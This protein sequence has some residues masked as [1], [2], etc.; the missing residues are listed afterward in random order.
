MNKILKNILHINIFNDILARR[1]EAAIMQNKIKEQIH[2]QAV[3]IAGRFR[4]AEAELVDILQQVERHYIYLQKGYQSLHAYVVKELALSENVA[5]N[6]ITVSRKAR[7]VPELKAALANGTIT[8]SNAR[9]I[10]PVLSAAKPDSLQWIN[11]AST[12][13]QRALEKEIVKVRPELATPERAVY[14]SSNAEQTRMRLE[15]GMSEE[16]LVK[17]RRVQDLLSQSRKKPVTLEE[18][19]VTLTDDYIKRNDPLE[20]AK[21]Q[22][23][24]KS[25][26]KTL[27][28]PV[29]LQVPTQREPI[30]ATLFHQIA[31]RDE[32]RCTHVNARGTRC[33][34]RRWIEIHHKIPVSLGGKNT[35]E[36]L[37][38]LC[39]THHRALHS[40]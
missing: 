34:Q 39:S 18:V 31:L 22:L 15:V 10:V 19:L 11:K 13:S 7:E 20:I 32:R 9:K 1:I 23:V 26:S 25:Q 38:T 40:Q 3:A 16:N 37:T 33:D 35:I 14:V 21:R 36:N 28:S 4:K 29:S 24:K 17:L 6:L 12:L 8:L 30:Y 5:Y 27:K 2:E